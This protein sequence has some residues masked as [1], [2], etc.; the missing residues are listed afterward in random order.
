MAVEQPEIKIDPYTTTIPLVQM[1]PEQMEAGS[2]PAQPLA[3]QFGGHRGSGA[4]AIGDAVLK[5]VLQGHELKEKRKNEQAQATIASADAATNASYQKYQDAIA[6]APGNTPEE[7]ANS[8]AAKAAYAAYIDTFNK[9]KEAKAQYVMPEKGQKGQQGGKGKEK[10]TGWANIKDW[11]E[12]NP[13]IVPSL[14]LATMQPKP[15][16]Q[17]Q[18]GR[19]AE[20]SRKEQEQKV[21]ENQQKIDA[22]KLRVSDENMVGTYGKLTQEQIAALPEDVK[23]QVLDPKTGLEAARYRISL[24]ETK[25]PKYDLF[26]D[27]QGHEHYLAPGQDVPPGWTRIEK[28]SGSGGGVK[29]GSVGDF[30]QTAADFNKLDVGKFSPAQKGYLEQLW[31]FFQTNP[32]AGSAGN[33]YVDGQGN[34]GLRDTPNYRGP[35]PPK[36][37]AGTFPPGFSLGGMQYAGQMASPPSQA[38]AP[39]AATGG[40]MAAPPGKPQATATQRMATP[41]HGGGKTMPSWQKTQFTNKAQEEQRKGWQKVEDNYQ[42]KLDKA[43]TLKSK[44]LDDAGYKLLLKDAADERVTE[45][46]EVEK[47]YAQAVHSIGGVVPSDNFDWNSL[48]TAQ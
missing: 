24:G 46:N 26:K 39:A 16:G 22:E 29:L 11:F 42:K 6:S 13:H 38:A 27:D 1:P 30:I 23:K 5:G 21:T 32:T 35:V 25:F 17:S 18:E 20:L 43:R 10:K 41:P 28:S 40:A 33:W 4:L 34:W 8:G 2:R 37:P 7:K 3:G 47:A 15:E 31:H 14:A 36:M 12:A 19:M 48:P 45:G 44:G 9:S